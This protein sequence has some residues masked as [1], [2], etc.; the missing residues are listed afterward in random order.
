MRKLFR[1]PLSVFPSSDDTLSSL[2]CL[3]GL[4]FSLRF[5]YHDPFLWRCRF[6][7]SGCQRPTLKDNTGGR[8]RTPSVVTDGI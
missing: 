1:C 8:L 6:N 2:I 3:L 7:L 4:F 5:P